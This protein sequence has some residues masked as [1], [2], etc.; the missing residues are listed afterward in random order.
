M[1]A[2]TTGT[3]LVAA[4]G[5]L[6]CGLL[7]TTS[8]IAQNTGA[9]SASDQADLPQP[10]APIQNP[11]ARHV[12][13]YVEGGI[14]GPAPI[15]FDNSGGA[16]GAGLIPAPCSPASGC[17]AGGTRS[18][19]QDVTQGLNTF[20][21]GA[22]TTAS[23][24]VADDFT[25]TGT[26]DLTT[27]SFFM[28]QTGAAATTIT[29]L[30]VRLHSS[31]APGAT[32]TSN[33][34]QGPLTGGVVSF[35]PTPIFRAVAATADCTRR[36]QQI[37]VDVSSWPPLAAGTY[38]LSWQATGTLASG[39]WQPPIT[40]CGACGKTG[41]NG[42]QATPATI[43]AGSFAAVVDTGGG[44]GCDNSPQDYPFI[45]RGTGGGAPCPA[46]IVNTGTSLNRVDVDDLLAVIG[47]WGN[48]PAPPATCPANVVNTGT[49]VNRVDVDDLLF[50]ISNWGNCP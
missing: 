44:V 24:T 13:N 5:T 35:E 28:Y 18:P 15:V 31:L 37:D 16:P 40:V 36:I 4:A 30:S 2:R 10:N 14:A 27:I 12:P 21:F 22:Q 17:P 25:L 45:I 50:I 1:H 34:L 42:L 23:N 20:G 8:T 48:C 19:L 11:A 47:G 9:T 39:P 7:L 32:P 38:W 3:A 46:N 26:T 41:A 49:S 43:P 33:V 6:F 29:G